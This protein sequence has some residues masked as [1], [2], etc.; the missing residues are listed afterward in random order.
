MSVITTLVIYD[1]V[2]GN[3]EKT[4]EAIGGAVVGEVRVLRTNYGFCPFPTLRFVVE[5]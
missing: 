5:F 3:M 1:S 2:Y 4:A